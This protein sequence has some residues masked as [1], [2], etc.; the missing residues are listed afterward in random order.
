MLNKTFSMENRIGILYRLLHLLYILVHI[1]V[2]SSVRDLSGAFF[3]RFV[4]FLFSSLY[5]LLSPFSFLHF[6]TM[7]YHSIVCVCMYIG[8]RDSIFR[9][10]NMFKHGSQTLTQTRVQCG[11][12]KYHIKLIVYCICYKLKMYIVRLLSLGFSFSIEFT[13]DAVFVLF[14]F[15]ILSPYSSAASFALLTL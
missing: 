10:K 5:H 12:K 15:N 3:V 9:E 8:K 1:F 11:H 7:C 13:F 2:E 6:Q 14:I 4:S